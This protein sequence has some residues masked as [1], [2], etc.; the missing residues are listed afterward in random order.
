MSGY[1]PARPRSGGGS[2]M[3]RSTRITLPLSVVL[4]LAA[5]ALPA[6]AIT[7]TPDSSTWMADGMIKASVQYA[8]G[9]GPYANVMFIGGVFSTVADHV[10]PDP[11]PATNSVTGLTGLA[12]ID[13]ST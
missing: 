12:A 9:T 1:H 13:M 6:H 4:V 2:E 7:S 3:R 5:G 10:K 8:P 11:T